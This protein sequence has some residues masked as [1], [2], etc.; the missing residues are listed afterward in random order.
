MS[1]F[2]QKLGKLDRP[3][4]FRLIFLVAVLLLLLLLPLSD[5]KYLVV[6][7]SNIMMYVVITVSW[8]LFS[9]TTRYISMASAAFFGIGVY[10]AAAFGRALPLPVV[11]GLGGLFSFCLALI[12]GTITLR[13]KG[14]YFAMFTLGIVEFIVTFLRWWEAKF[15]GTVGRLVVYVDYTT[16]YYVMLLIFLVLMLTAF[17]LGRSKV[18]LALKG[19]GECEEAAAHVGINTNGLK[20]VTF[21][22]STFFI[23][24]TGVIMATR[25][26]YIDPQI[27]FNLQY[28]LLPILMAI[29]G[30]MDKLYGPVV[31]AVFFAY[32]EEFLITKLPY[33]YMLIFGTTLVVVILY[34]PEGLTGLIQKLRKRGSEGRHAHS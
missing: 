9:G 27:A 23:G 3:G 33:Y 20:V 32:L 11:I 12:I 19:I 22:V 21:A 17:L 18:G 7:F 31:G 6:L 10:T 5:S 15:S 14:I 34:L 28:S 16:V 4:L 26:T 24:A 25:W 8:T 1:L 29:I 13:L 30:G 2:I